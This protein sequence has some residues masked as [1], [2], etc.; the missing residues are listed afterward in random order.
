MATQDIFEKSGFKALGITDEVTACDRCGK[1]HLARTVVLET[2]KGDIVHYGTTCAALALTG[3]RDRS[4]GEV[5]WG[6]ALM[7]QRCKDVLPIVLAAIAAGK[8]PKKAAGPRFLVCHGHYSDT[9]NKAPL[10]I[11]YDGYM[12]P[13]VVIPADQY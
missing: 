1:T 10:R 11:F 13:G 4:T 9:G 8:C 7:V 12:F 2:P 6:R 5:I 3:R